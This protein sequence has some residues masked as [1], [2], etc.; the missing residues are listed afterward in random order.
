MTNSKKQLPINLQLKDDEYVQFG[1]ITHTHS[2]GNNCE[3]P[4][5]IVTKDQIINFGRSHSNHS[6]YCNAKNISVADNND[7]TLNCIELNTK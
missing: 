1:D 7:Q 5:Q 2:I 4:V 6:V 3:Y